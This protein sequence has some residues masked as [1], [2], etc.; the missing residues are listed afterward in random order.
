MSVFQKSLGLNNL[1]MNRAIILLG[2]NKGNSSRNLE[3][4]KAFIEKNAGK[5]VKFSGTYITE[6]W[7]KTDQPFFLNQVVVVDTVLTARQLINMLLLIEEKMGRK[8]VEKWESRLID[9]DILFFN[10]DIIEEE[11]LV[12]PHPH[13]H[14]RRFTLVPLAEIMP[15]F[16]HP[17]FG[18]NI[19]T[20]LSE[21]KDNLRVNLSSET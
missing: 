12:I 14:E 20:L 17:V 18:K 5:I 15:G 16:N 10:N 4:S 13:L 8:R 7:G 9:L 2:S 3:E 19:Q 6:P 1:K 11:G 21:L